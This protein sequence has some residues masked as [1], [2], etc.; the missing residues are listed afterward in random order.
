MKRFMAPLSVLFCSLFSVAADAQT[1]LDETPASQP[2]SQQ[3]S[4]TAPALTLS[5]GPEKHSV[6]S[7]YSTSIVMTGVWVGGIFATI[8]FAEKADASFDGAEPTEPVDPRDLNAGFALSTGSKLAFNGALLSLGLARYEQTHKARPLYLV[9][10]AGLLNAAARDLGFIVYTAEGSIF[11]TNS[12]SDNGIYG[13]AYVVGIVSALA[14][15][16]YATVKAVKH[17]K[18]KREAAIKPD[19]CFELK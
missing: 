10:T 9:A 7:L 13:P 1:P 2:V 18:A 14:L 11:G 19:E 3:M 12:P 15:T 8:P 16:T 4:N 5:Q 6:G 17:T